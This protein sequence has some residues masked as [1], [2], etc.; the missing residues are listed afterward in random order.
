MQRPD[1]YPLFDVTEEGDV[2]PDPEAVDEYGWE[3]PSSHNNST[4]TPKLPRPRKPHP[5]AGWVNT[6]NAH[7]NN[8]MQALTEANKRKG[9]GGMSDDH[10]AAK[11]LD[12]KYAGGRNG[13]ASRGDQFFEDFKEELSLACGV[14][15]VQCFMKDRPDIFETKYPKSADREKLKNKLKKVPNTQC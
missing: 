3:D 9:A 15:A 7:L 10:P 4:P 8:A 5:A 6:R 13:I 12:G 14:C 1:T 2:I 11:K